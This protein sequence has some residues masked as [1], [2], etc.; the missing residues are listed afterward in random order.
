MTPQ[1]PTLIWE[2]RKCGAIIELDNRP[3]KCSCGELIW[4]RN[5][6]VESLWQKAQDTA[7]KEFAEEIKKLAIKNYGVDLIITDI[8]MIDKLLQEKQT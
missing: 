3:S 5:V 6:Q 8:D 2:C 7:L 4:F 1:T